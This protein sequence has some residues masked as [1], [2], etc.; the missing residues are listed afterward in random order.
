MGVVVHFRI[1]LALLVVACYVGECVPL[2]L[3]DDHVHWERSSQ[4]QIGVD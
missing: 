2:G 3:G 1:L 4:N